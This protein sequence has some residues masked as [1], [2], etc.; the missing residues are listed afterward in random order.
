MEGSLH[1]RSRSRSPLQHEQ[2]RSSSPP[3]SLRTVT[4]PLNN[5]SDDVLSSQSDPDPD[6]DPDPDSDAQVHPSS[7]AP[8]SDAPDSDGPDSQVDSDSSHEDGA[9]NEDY[10][11]ILKEITRRWLHI[12]SNHNISKTA[13][14]K[15]W[16]LVTAEF[17]NL[18]RA[19]ES[20]N[21][22]RKIPQLQQ[23][24]KQ[25]HK[26]LPTINMEIGYIHKESGEIIVEKNLRSTPRKRYSPAEYK[27]AFEIAT[28]KVK[29]IHFNC[30]FSNKILYL[31]LFLV[32]KKM[33][34]NRLCDR[35]ISTC[36]H[37]R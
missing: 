29:T 16:R 37:P 21:I 24:R 18:L 28:V 19:R 27:K 8:D 30:I 20:E 32:S 2:R 31:F 3:T 36:R 1:S 23:L 9:E 33:T 14:D 22:S 35:L 7:D 15:L 5:N 34:E 13:S 4:P 12:E 25:T 11:S 6:P 17:S 10:F 26:N